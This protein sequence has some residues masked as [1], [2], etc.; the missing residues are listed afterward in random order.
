MCDPNVAGGPLPTAA[1]SIYLFIFQDPNSPEAQCLLTLQ[2]QTQGP[3]PV[4]DVGASG[5]DSA[6][7]LH[8]TPPSP[9]S[10][11]PKFFQ[12]LCADDCNNPIGSADTQIYSVCENGVLS[13]RDLTSGGSSSGGVD[14]GVIASTDMSF[15]S[16]EVNVGNLGQTGPVAHTNATFCPADMGVDTSADGGIFGPGGQNG[17]SL[18]DPAYVCTSSLGPGESGARI[19]GL[20]NGQLYHFR[21]V[22]VDAFGNATSSD[23]IDGIPQPTEDLWRRYRDAGGGPGGCFIATAAFGSYENR[24]VYVLRDFRDQVLLEHDFGRAFVDWYYAN[25]P[26]PAAWIAQHGGV[27]AI[28]RL[29]LVPL[30]AAAWF[31]LY[32]PPVQKALVLLV[33]FALI[34]RKRI[35]RR[36]DRSR[37]A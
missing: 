28:T 34:F 37:T 27:R 18:L 15:T 30:I 5:G 21:V 1:N 36:L 23:Q 13:R 25:S 2:E 19:T 16:L 11:A 22:S 7:E 20:V 26:R 33:V 8:W 31:W 14:G 12:V 35:R 4:T 32:V 24:W 3:V 10:Y 9:A 6:I 17:L 29:F